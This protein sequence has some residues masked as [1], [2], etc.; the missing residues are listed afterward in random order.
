MSL[1]PV[2]FFN[3]SKYYL[4]KSHLLPNKLFQFYHNLLLK[5]MLLKSPMCTCYHYNFFFKNRK[6][7][8]IPK[9]SHE[10]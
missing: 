1:I 4:A 6:L 9:C 10:I 2:Y 5:D 3:V 7:I 8:E